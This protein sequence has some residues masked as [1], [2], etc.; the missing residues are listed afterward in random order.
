MPRVLDELKRLEEAHARGDI[1][2]EKLAQ[3]RR[4]L[5]DIVE[6]AEVSTEPPEPAPTQQGISWRAGFVTVSGLTVLTAFVSWL[7]EDVALALTL[8]AT[9]LAGL[10]IN[11]ARQI[12]AEEQAMAMPARPEQPKPGPALDRYDNQGRAVPA[13]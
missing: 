3:L 4:D 13:E 8:S 9:L 5:L 1:P 10:V 7:T 12:A 2:A 6:E 11:A